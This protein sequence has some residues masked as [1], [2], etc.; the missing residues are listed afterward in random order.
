ME[1][2]SFGALAMS[3]GLRDHHDSGMAQLGEEI[4]GAFELRA[5]SGPY[6]RLHCFLDAIPVFPCQRQA[7]PSVQWLGEQSL[8]YV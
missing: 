2:V 8:V 5:F 3:L 7:A 4:A 6:D 1:G